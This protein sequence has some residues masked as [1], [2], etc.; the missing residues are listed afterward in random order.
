MSLSCPLKDQSCPLINNSC[1]RGSYVEEDDFDCDDCC[2]LGLDYDSGYG[3]VYL[4]RDHSDPNGYPRL[5]GHD[6]DVYG[7]HFNAQSAP[8][9]RGGSR[10]GRGGGRGRRRSDGGMGG[11]RG[12]RR[13]DG[14]ILPRVIGGI[15]G[16]AT[17]G[18]L[19]PYP[20]SSS[21][22]FYPNDPR[23]FPYPRHNGG[24]I[25][26]RRPFFPGSFAGLGWLRSRWFMPYASLYS[27]WY[28]V[29]ARPIFVID[30]RTNQYVLNAEVPTPYPTLPLPYFETQLPF[31]AYTNR[32]S[33]NAFEQQAL[34]EAL[35]SINDQYNREIVQ[36]VALRR[37]YKAWLSNGFAIVPDLTEH[38][39][40]W[41]YTAM[42]P[43][44]TIYGMQKLMKLSCATCDGAKEKLIKNYN[45]DD[46]IFDL[47]G[48]HEDKFTGLYILKNGDMYSYT[49]TPGVTHD[50]DEI[51][52]TFIGNKTTEKE[53]NEMMGMVKTAL[54]SPVVQGRHDSGPIV[55]TGMDENGN[56]VQFHGDDDTT[57]DA[58]KAL[59]MRIR[60]LA[61]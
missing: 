39:F 22:P 33:L 43:N 21:H 29:N 23:Y 59:V 38:K 36:G 19:N 54:E 37:E 46:V 20:G 14:D 61:S 17:R 31:S 35:Q 53:M 10:G 50:K 15:I 26:R 5:P 55:Y 60:A 51:E 58:S 1:S 47:Y 48:K 57:S 18:I 32:D 7:A 4:E 44:T 34:G 49:I 9:A 25:R 52:T 42:N 28:P 11:G 56:R 12:Q 13:S 24:G 3:K 40:V 2:D 41:V 8:D 6:S 45:R 16:G 27:S 30:D